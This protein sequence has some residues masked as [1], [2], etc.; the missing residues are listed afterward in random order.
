MPAFMS[1]APR[2]HIRPS[3]T[4]SSPRIVAPTLGRLD[5][6]HVDVAAQMERSPAAGA[7]QS[8]CHARSSLVRKDRQAGARIIPLAACASG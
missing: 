4:A 8:A 1:P 3:A 6:N 2:P 5:G 7:R